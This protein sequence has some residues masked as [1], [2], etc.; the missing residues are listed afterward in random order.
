MS[1]PA[2]H[3][4]ASASSSDYSDKASTALRAAALGLIA[5]AW[6]LMQHSGVPV[7]D[8]TALAPAKLPLLTLAGLVLAVL[9]LVIDAGQYA[10]ATW[11]Y[12]RFA[13]TVELTLSEHAEL[14]ATQRQVNCAWRRAKT[15]GIVGAI[16]QETNRSPD[17]YRQSPDEGVQLARLIIQQAH[18]Y[19][20]DPKAK[21]KWSGSGKAPTNKQLAALWDFFDNEWTR[22]RTA[23]AIAVFFYAKV[24]AVMASG[25]VLG[26][27][28]GRIY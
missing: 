2:I 19:R 16:L 1:D 10:F 28:L 27:Y 6:F 11:S 13:H 23:T 18:L 8:K 15:N 21:R 4:F 24:I 22:R 12:S 14:V 20:A 9:A 25:I 17:A 3:A 5:A 7:D 26:V